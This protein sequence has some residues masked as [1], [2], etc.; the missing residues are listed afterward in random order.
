M[1][2]PDPSA[3]LNV[4]LEDRRQHGFGE[5]QPQTRTP[6][7]S[8]RCEYPSSSMEPTCVSFRFSPRY[9]ILTALEAHNWFL[10][11]MQGHEEFVVETDSTEELPMPFLSETVR[12]GYR[13][14]RRRV[15]RDDG[16]TSREGQFRCQGVFSRVTPPSQESTWRVNRS[17]ATAS[18]AE[19][20]AAAVVAANRCARGRTLTRGI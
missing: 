15:K 19:K 6:R 18:A 8:V 13:H 9:G 14:A 3:C 10:R 2:S 16:L 12:R 1:N 20:V 11:M 7:L 4:A 5:V 17:A